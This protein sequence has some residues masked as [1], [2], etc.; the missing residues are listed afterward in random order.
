LAEAQKSFTALVEGATKNAP[1]GTES[2]VAFF[3]NAMNASQEAFKTAQSSAQQAIDVAQ[4]NFTA[5]SKQAVS[6][7]KK[8]S[9]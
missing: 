3:N 9:K 2:V 8:A 5:A 4:S 6:A 7:V 1:A